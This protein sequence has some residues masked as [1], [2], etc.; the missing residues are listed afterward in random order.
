MD[1][2]NYIL[3]H[4]LGTSGNKA[5]LYDG[6]GVLRCSVV[7]GYPTHYPHDG[8]VE[9]D[10]RAPAL[11]L[12]AATA[13]AVEQIKSPSRAD[14]DGGTGGKRSFGASISV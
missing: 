6:D 10:R 7:C 11:L 2:R 4:D 14:R 5:T 12:L 8:Q 13:G 3:A 1:T 9:Q